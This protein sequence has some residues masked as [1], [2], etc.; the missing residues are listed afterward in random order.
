MPGGPSPYVRKDVAQRAEDAVAVFDL[1]LQRVSYLD[2]ELIT[3]AP[4]G[5]TGGRRI[6]RTVAC[7]LVK[8]EMQRRVD[9]KVDEWRAI[10]LTTLDQVIRDHWRLRT[11]NWDKAMAGEERPALA[12]DR[13]LNG[14]VRAISAQNKLLGLEITRIEAE[15]VEVTEQDLELREMIRSAKAQAAL[16]EQEIRGG[17]E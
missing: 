3:S 7:D 11:A 16:E 5:P 9:P 17:A 4:D 1:A 8:E 15:V 12:V 13:A 10:Q 14:V 2:I 6:S